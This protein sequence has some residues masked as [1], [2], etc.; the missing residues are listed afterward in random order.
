MWTLPHPPWAK[1]YMFSE[2]FEKKIVSFNCFL[3]K[4]F[5]PPRK[6]LLFPGKNRRQINPKE[7]KI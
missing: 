1:N 3:C 4:M 5:P 2:D 7:F 6:N